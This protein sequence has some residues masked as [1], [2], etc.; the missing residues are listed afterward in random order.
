MCFFSYTLTA[1]PS[2]VTLLLLFCSSSLQRQH[3]L[4]KHGLVGLDCCCFL[5]IYLH[6]RSDHA[7]AF[8]CSSELI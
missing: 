7:R 2:L 3:H 8:V 6:N 4:V 1:A 5:Q